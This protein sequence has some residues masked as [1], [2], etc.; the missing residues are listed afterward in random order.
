MN[1]KL[2]ALAV[3]TAL[4]LAPVV[5]PQAKVTVYGHAQVEVANIDVSIGG[6][7]GD[8][9]TVSDNARGRIGIKAS[10]KLGNGMTAIAKFEFK[11]D[12]ADGYADDANGDALDRRESLVGLKGNFGTVELGTLKSAYKYSGGVTYDAFTA[13]FLEARGAG[14]MSGAELGNKSFGH[15]SFL[16]NSIAYKTPNFNG[17]TGWVT[18]SPDE[19]GDGK[20][21]DGDFSYGLNYRNGP[22]EVGV[23]GITNDDPTGGDAMKVYGKYKF[24]NHTVLGQYEAIDSD[25]IGDVD[26]YFVGYQ[27]KM[28]NNTLV[29]QL[30]NSEYDDG[31]ELDYVSIGA[32]HNLSK[33]TR[34]FG[35]YASSETDGAEVETVSVGLRMIF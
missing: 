13:T 33:K 32:I 8:A 22:F 6:L 5:A 16:T 17:L 27:M 20:G 11:V 30:G 19:L 21:A 14:G 9:T 3:G 35:G 1:K 24:G 4:G 28:G 34:L 10:E 31:S 18:Y 29:V 2:A 23:A 15:Y 26:I 7:S 12:T 25:V